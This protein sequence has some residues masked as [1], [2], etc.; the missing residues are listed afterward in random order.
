MNDTLVNDTL[1]NDTLFFKQVRERDVSPPTVAS[2]GRG[3]DPLNVFPSTRDP[4]HSRRYLASYPNLHQHGSH[5]LTHYHDRSASP[6]RGVHQRREA[7][8]NNGS[9]KAVGVKYG[10]HGEAVFISEMDTEM[11]RDGYG[12]MT[13]SQ[14]M[15]ELQQQLAESRREVSDL[16]DESIKKMNALPMGEKQTAFKMKD[17][18]EKERHARHSLKKSQED[19]E[20]LRWQLEHADTAKRSASMAASS[21][22]DKALSLAQIEFDGE[23][24]GTAFS[25]FRFMMVRWKRE[26]HS[27]L[28]SGWQNEQLRNERDGYRYQ[29]EQAL[30][31]VE[32]AS[33]EVEMIKRGL[34]LTLTLTLTLIGG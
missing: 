24:K 34:T 2:K 17:L 29:L 32:T 7:L 8:R 28:L 23:N 19:N 20:K 3:G 31:I 10:G 18:E 1:R 15:A 9:G 16:R 27:A 11:D 33:E 13:V 22:A 4:S 25:Q 12:D 6:T 21:R 26:K 30:M 5:A 14:R